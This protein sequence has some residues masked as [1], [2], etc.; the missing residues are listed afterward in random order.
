L[1]LRAGSKPWNPG[2]WTP[3]TAS[4]CPVIHP[5][6]QPW[7]QPEILRSKV[8]DK[9]SETAASPVFQPRFS[10]YLRHDPCAH[11]RQAPILGIVLY[12]AELRASDCYQADCIDASLPR[13]TVEFPTIQEMLSGSA[14]N[15][16]NKGIRAE[17]MSVDSASL[18]TNESEY[19]DFLAKQ[20]G[21]RR[22]RTMT[23]G[24]FVGFDP[25]VPQ[26]T[27][28]LDLDAK[29]LSLVK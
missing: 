13:H 7:I 9:Y 1:D 25:T 6:V 21:T 16:W 24:I 5:S 17:V 4:S 3:G 18:P 23:L 14:P 26:H 15:F 20:W 12:E 8:I 29:T 22:P 11:P 10:T 27:L 19:P 28:V 2:E